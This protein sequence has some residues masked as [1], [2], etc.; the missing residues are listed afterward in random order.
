MG[1]ADDPAGQT[2][3]TNRNAT[4]QAV[5][6]GS[7]VHWRIAVKSTGG[8][9]SMVVITVRQGKVW[10]SIDPPSAWEAIMEPATV[11]GLI[12]TLGAARDD[13]RRTRSPW[14]DLLTDS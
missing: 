1:N 12:R 3:Y 4:G 13:A 2:T 5:Y 6:V 11:D 7:D 14:R 9:R 8:A 10:L